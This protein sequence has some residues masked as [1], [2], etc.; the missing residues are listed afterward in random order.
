MALCVRRFSRILL[1]LYFFCTTMT[2]RWAAPFAVHVSCMFTIEYP[3]RFTFK[4]VYVRHSQLTLVSI[5]LFFCRSFDTNLLQPACVY[6]T[7]APRGVIYRKQKTQWRRQEVFGGN[8]RASSS[9][10]RGKN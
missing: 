2:S 6:H 9:Q 10:P 3:E 1:V 5:V 7:T 4:F 8:F